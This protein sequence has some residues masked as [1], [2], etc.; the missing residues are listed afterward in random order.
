M[1]KKLSNKELIG[2]FS[3]GYH[4]FDL[5][6]GAEICKRAGLAREWARDD[7]T[8]CYGSGFSIEAAR[9]DSGFYSVLWLAIQKLSK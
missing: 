5:E 7:G 1:Y 8:G 2:I 4:N 6:L 9:D 3:S